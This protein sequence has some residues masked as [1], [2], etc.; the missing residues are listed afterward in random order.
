MILNKFD[1]RLLKV[2]REC[3]RR[4]AQVSQHLLQC[5]NPNPDR[6]KVAVESL[7]EVGRRPVPCRVDFFGNLEVMVE[8]STWNKGDGRGDEEVVRFVVNGLDDCDGQIRQAAMQT[9][10]SVCKEEDATVMD[11]IAGLLSDQSVYV[12]MKAMKMVSSI[13]YHDVARAF[14]LLCDMLTDPDATVR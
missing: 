4:R 7:A 8:E 2:R 9:L 12:K 13:A 14:R 1:L 11:K 10:P 6:R 3:E 5:S